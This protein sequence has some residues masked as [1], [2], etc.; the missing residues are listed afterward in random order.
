MRLPAWSPAPPSTTMMPRRNRSPA[1]AA[2]PPRTMTIPPRMPETSPASG[3]PRRSP[4]EPA[5][6]IRA[7]LHARRRPVVGVSLDRQATPGHQPARLDADVPGG[8][9]RARRSCLRRS[10]RA[11]RRHL[12]CGCAARRPCAAGRHRRPV[13]RTRVVCNGICAISCAVLPAS[14]CGT[15]GD[16]SRRCSGRPRNVRNS[17]ASRQQVL[18][19][20]MMRP[21][22]PAVIPG[23]DAHRAAFGPELCRSPR[24][25]RASRSA[26]ASDVRPSTTISSTEADVGGEFGF[27]PRP[28][29][30]DYRPRWWTQ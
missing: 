1:R 3:P 6:S 30:S 22:L 29:A 12:R 21:E 13:A 14:R 27:G 7:A 20:V 16:R 19:V 23:A 26:T 8:L 9:D 24:S 28:A 17:A 11:G 25:R 18:E 10:G 15:S 2:T 4:A 5:I